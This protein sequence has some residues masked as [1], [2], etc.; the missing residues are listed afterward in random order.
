MA[1]LVVLPKLGLTMTEGTVSNWRKAKGDRVEQGDIL[2]DVET[3]K[4]SNEIEAKTSGVLREILVEEGTVEVFHPLAIIADASE[5]ISALLPAGATG[6]PSEGE[7]TASGNEASGLTVSGEE[8]EAAEEEAVQEGPAAHGGR[9]KASPL[10]RRTAKELGVELSSL[11]GTGPQGR[12]TDGD[13]RHYAESVQHG[14]P[15]VRISPAAAKEAAAL[16]VNPADIHKDGRIMKE[17]VRSFAA[18]GGAVS[19][20]AG[21]AP[22]SVSGSRSAASARNADTEEQAVS[23]VPMSAMRKVIAKRMR[24]SVDISPTVTYN[25]RVDTT[26]LAALRRQ[27][28][29][30]RKITYTD[31][32]VAITAKAL[33]EFP[34]LNCSIE[35]N[36]LVLRNAVHIGVAVGL[37]SGL[38][39]PVVRNAQLKGL[40]EISDEVRFLAEGARNNT[41]TPADMTGGTF[42]IT[43][44][45]M[46]GM[47]SFSPI[48]NQPEVAILG[49]NT[50][51]DTPVAVNGE[52]VIKPLMN[53]SLTADH[54]A[55]DGADAAGFLQRIKAYAENP[56]LL[57]L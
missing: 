56:A 26:A 52:V 14:S 36:D 1:E 27:L 57:L 7:P 4:I 38:V 5:D 22:A 13:V 54:R 39:V 8:A 46:Y 24:E 9:I 32:L 19:A 47:E 31:L 33:L 10:A 25:M 34:L 44:L 51:V 23:R 49:V 35:G 17:D 11:K 45:G 28:K 15:K 20:I 50:I 18:T 3:D 2:F 12:I 29:D 37:D 16:G 43:N 48:I 55:V 42:T 41:L 30:S 6:K 21:Q 40:G 53:L